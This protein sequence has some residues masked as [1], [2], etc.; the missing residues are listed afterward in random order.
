MQKQFNSTMK[1]LEPLVHGM[2]WEHRG[3]YGHWLAQTWFFV[4]ESTRLLNLCG[5]HLPQSMEDMHNR[6]I[7]HAKEEQGHALSLL[8]DLKQ[9]GYSID[10]YFEE[11]ETAVFYQSQYYLIQHKSPLDFFGYILLLEGVAV[12]FGTQIW[13]R[14]KA[15][16]GQRSAGFLQVHGAEDPDH[17]EKA[18]KQLEGLNEP[19]KASLM[20]N[21][22]QSAY[23][24][25]KILSK[26]ALR[27]QTVS[28]EG[29]QRVA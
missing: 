5:A 9:L 16:H 26:S 12:E 21:F 4:K 22:Q 20:S 18:F 29:V 24:Y 11:P 28:G 3:V 15:A 10:E 7:D 14:V 6:F 13:E 2:N 27:G 1:Q 19:A 17:L 23:F 25:Q 8:R